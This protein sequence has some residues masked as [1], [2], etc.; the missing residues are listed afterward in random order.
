[1]PYIDWPGEWESG[2]R[3]G[4]GASGVKADLRLLGGVILRNG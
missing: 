4:E 2:D 1:M 3:E